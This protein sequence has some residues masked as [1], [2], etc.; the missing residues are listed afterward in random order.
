[1]GLVSRV[2]GV[3]RFFSGFFGVLWFLRVLRL[4]IPSCTVH[5]KP[6]GLGL[7]GLTVGVRRRCRG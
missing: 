5:L 6:T 2:L 7:F 1:M 4:G 3:L